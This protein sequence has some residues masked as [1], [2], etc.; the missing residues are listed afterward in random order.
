MII[1]TSSL[2]KDKNGDLTIFREEKIELIISRGTLE[3]ERD[4]IRVK[5][6]SEDGSYL[7]QRF[8]L[9]VPDS[10]E[11]KIRFWSCESEQIG[12]LLELGEEE[13][14]KEKTFVELD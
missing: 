13:D 1:L 7:N 11:V 2:L 12:S 6:L 5:L 3:K 9:E 14:I 4:N 10:I 8:E